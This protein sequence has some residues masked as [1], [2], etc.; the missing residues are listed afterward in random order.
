MMSSESEGS[1]IRERRSPRSDLGLQGGHAGAALTRVSDTVLLLQVAQDIGDAKLRLAAVQATGR[2]KG[3]RSV[4][5]NLTNLASS[6]AATRADALSAIQTESPCKK[7]I[8]PHFHFR[9]FV[10]RILWQCLPR[11]HDL[12][13]DHASAA[14]DPADPS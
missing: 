11:Q 14:H 13:R 12:R 1:A 6:G 2:F 10:R 8:F 5:N 3:F 7:R 4:S 9:T